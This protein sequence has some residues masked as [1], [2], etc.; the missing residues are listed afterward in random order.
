ML[1]SRGH[2]VGMPDRSSKRPRDMNQLANLIADRATGQAEPEKPDQGK[3]P[4]AVSLGRRGG[5]KGGKARAKSLSREQLSVAAR[6][7]ANARWRG[8]R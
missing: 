7:A 6:K 3:D 1:C 4:A 2:S 8:K 5:L